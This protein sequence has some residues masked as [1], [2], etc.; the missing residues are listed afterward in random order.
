MISYAEQKG[1]VVYV[2]DENNHIL[3]SKSGRLNDYTSSTVSFRLD[4]NMI[5]VFDD[6]GNY[7]FTK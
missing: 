7:K 1:S 2:Y 3:F 5:Q 4:N 6:R